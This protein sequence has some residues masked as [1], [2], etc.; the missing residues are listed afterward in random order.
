VA[1]PNAALEVTVEPEVIGPMSKPA[2][3]ER[4]PLDT[5]PL[6]NVNV[7][8]ATPPV[9]P[10]DTG[11]PH[12]DPP[13]SGEHGLLSPRSQKA[14]NSPEPYN[15]TV[16]GNPDADGVLEGVMLGVGVI[17]DVGVGGGVGAGVSDGVGLG[18]EEAAGVWVLVGVGVIVLVA[19][20]VGVG[21]VPGDGVSDIVGVTDGVGL[22]P[23]AGVCVLVGVG[24]GVAVEPGVGVTG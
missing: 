12:P 23:G 6:L 13:G 10:K 17:E 1:E 14:F 8:G 4:V 20:G 24:V 15:W 2:D 22:T 7:Y 11:V 5:N 18:A 16:S 21:E 3:T 19:D 9:T